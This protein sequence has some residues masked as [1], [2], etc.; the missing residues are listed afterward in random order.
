MATAIY[1]VIYARENWWVD[2][3]G[4]SQGPFLSLDAATSEAIA[5]ADRTARRGGRS[6]VQ[7]AEPGTKN[8]IVYQSP[9]PSLLSRAAALVN[10]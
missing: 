4:Q 2:L 8:R 5:M 6:E 7:V 1:I 9:S 10:H 3:D